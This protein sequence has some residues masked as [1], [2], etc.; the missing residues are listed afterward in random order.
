MWYYYFSVAML[1]WVSCQMLQGVLLWREDSQVLRQ[2]SLSDKGFPLTCFFR[3]TAD[4]PMAPAVSW[5]CVAEFSVET[6]DILILT[7]RS[8]APGAPSFKVH[9]FLSLRY[10]FWCGCNSGVPADVSDALPRGLT[11]LRGEALMSVDTAEI[12][13]TTFFCRKFF[14]RLGMY[15]TRGTWKLDQ[16][17]HRF[18][19]LHVHPGAY[20]LLKGRAVQTPVDR[21]SVATWLVKNPLQCIAGFKSWPPLDLPVHGQVT[22]PLCCF[23]ICE[24]GNHAYLIGY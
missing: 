17:E 16:Q 12:I 10:V 21:A 14:Q 3:N 13:R 18:M 9:V 5:V 8:S 1:L 20:A 24:M 2:I 7:S 22:W 15:T 19:V 6:L 11:L 4:S 23:F